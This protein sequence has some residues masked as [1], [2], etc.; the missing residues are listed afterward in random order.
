MP[1]AVKDVVFTSFV[2]FFWFYSRIRLS[3]HDH[4]RIL[5]QLSARSNA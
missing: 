5:Q 2:V 3:C 4:G 1:F